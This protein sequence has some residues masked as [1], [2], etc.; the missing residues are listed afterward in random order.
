LQINKLEEKAHT[1]PLWQ[2]K[3]FTFL[4]PPQRRNI[5]ME[6]KTGWQSKV[7]GNKSKSCWHFL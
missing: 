1:L 4:V 7:E 3:A 6:K 2:I 5:I